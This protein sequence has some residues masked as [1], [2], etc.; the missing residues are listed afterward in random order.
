MSFPQMNRPV[1][2]SSR[3]LVDVS[4]GTDWAEITDNSEF[5]Q[6]TSKND[7]QNYYKSVGIEHSYNTEEGNDIGANVPW[8]SITPS[9]LTDDWVGPDNIEKS[10]YKCSLL[11]DGFQ[12]SALLPVVNTI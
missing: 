6:V 11:Y 5:I 12:E 8:L 1:I 7:D 4:T 2:P 9:A 10:Y 3:Y